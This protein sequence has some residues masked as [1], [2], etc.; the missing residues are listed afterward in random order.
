MTSEFVY[1]YPQW[2]RG[3]LSAELAATQKEDLV[4]LVPMV[5]HYNP[6]RSW[7]ITHPRQLICGGTYCAD[8]DP[9]HKNILGFLAGDSV[10]GE[11]NFRLYRDADPKKWEREFLSEFALNV[12][13][14]YWQ[15]QMRLLELRGK[16]EDME[17]LYEQDYLVS[18]RGRRIAQ[19]ERVLRDGGDML[20]PLLWRDG[21]FMAYSENGYENREWLWNGGENVSAFELTD[22]GWRKAEG[23]AR[24]QNGRVVLSLKP[25]EALLI[26]EDR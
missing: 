12:P 9:E 4:G 10:L 22:E 11:G 20:M 17:A 23:R 21:E 8:I 6:P 18:F 7:Y 16:D 1:N 15:N 13:A 19:G 25:R 5:W 26:C 3:E 24:V 14:W 2:D